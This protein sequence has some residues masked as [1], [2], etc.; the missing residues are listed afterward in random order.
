[1]P[2]PGRVIQGTV[3]PARLTSKSLGL[4]ERRCDSQHPLRRSTKIPENP[5]T[6]DPRQSDRT[7]L[8]SILLKAGR[9][10][11]RF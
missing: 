7:Y 8:P 2:D 10:S 4:S 1:M 3:V 5:R 6:R 11:T 9:V